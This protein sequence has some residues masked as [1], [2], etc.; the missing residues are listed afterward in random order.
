MISSIPGDLPPAVDLVP[1]PA[2]AQPIPPHGF[3]IED[4]VTLHDQGMP[5]D[6]I[7]GFKGEVQGSIEAPQAATGAPQ[8]EAVPRMAPG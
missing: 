3:K 7:A 6:Y 2:K 5:E 1:S 8:P 4:T